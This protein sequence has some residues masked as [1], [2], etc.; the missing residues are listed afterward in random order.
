MEFNSQKP[1]ANFATLEQ[2]V[3]GDIDAAKAKFLRQFLDYFGDGANYT[4]HK[5]AFDNTTAFGKVVD[6]L[7]RAKPPVLVDILIIISIFSRNG[8]ILLSKSRI[9]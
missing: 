5:S 2:A 4:T 3:S 9:S 7:N 6:Q 8:W 1:E